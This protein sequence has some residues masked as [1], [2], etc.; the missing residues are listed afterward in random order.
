MADYIER[1]GPTFPTF[2]PDRNTSPY[3]LGWNTCL[4]SIYQ[5]SAADARP[6]VHGQWVED[7]DNQPVSCDKV[8][9]CSNCKKNRRFEWQLKPFCEECGADMR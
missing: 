9:C 4:R 5:H 1:S 8:Y 6:V 7:G 2:Y 3:A